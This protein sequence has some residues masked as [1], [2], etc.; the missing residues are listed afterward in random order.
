MSQSG[1]EHEI[2]G[3]TQHPHIID[4]TD[5]T[6]SVAGKTSPIKE[7]LK[8]LGGKYSAKHRAYNFPI[9]R[10]EEVE[11]FLKG[12]QKEV[13]EGDHSKKGGSQGQSAVG[14]HGKKSASAESGDE[15]Q[16]GGD[17]SPTAGGKR[18]HKG[19]TAAHHAKKARAE[20][21]IVEAPS[22]ESGQVRG[23]KKG[24]RAAQ[25][26]GEAA[27]GGEEEQGEVSGHVPMTDAPP[28]K[29]GGHTAT[30]KPGP[31]KPY[32]VRHTTRTCAVIGDVAQYSAELEKHGGK[33]NAGIKIGTDKYAGWTFQQSKVDIVRQI[34]PGIAEINV[35]EEG[36]GA[37]LEGTKEGGKEGK[38]KGA[39]GAAMGAGA[40]GSQ[41]A[42]QEA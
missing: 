7:Q 39:E 6:F 14:S 35:G 13:G 12:M 16:G 9:K 27:E 19:T 24:V 30:T 31:S 41:E 22:E 29:S 5:K 37:T 11:Q 28:E 32:L 15:G 40:L 17:Q 2:H 20:E 18:E 1:E 33:H 34:I 42:A 10:K 26:K 38:R 4:L 25:A 21:D 3:S 8:E 36:I 23:G